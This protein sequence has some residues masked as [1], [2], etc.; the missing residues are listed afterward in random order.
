MRNLLMKR[1]EEIR[2]ML[3]CRI[4]IELEECIGNWKSF[5]EGDTCWIK[6]S[7][8]VQIYW[9]CFESVSFIHKLWGI[10]IWLSRYIWWLI[11]LNLKT[12]NYLRK[13]F[14]LLSISSKSRHDLKIYCSK[15]WITFHFYLVSE[16]DKLLLFMR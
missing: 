15:Y 5:D 11:M 16:I 14:I 6:V 1:M 2:R 3:N 7:S 10:D 12:F 9:E 8:N 4:L 13:L